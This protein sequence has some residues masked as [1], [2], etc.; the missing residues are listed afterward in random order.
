MT[1]ERTIGE[2]K[3][4]LIS[5]AAGLFVYGSLT[6]LNNVLTGKYQ[7]GFV[8]KLIYE[9]RGRQNFGMLETLTI[10]VMPYIA[11]VIPAAITYKLVRE[12]LD[13]V[14]PDIEQRM[15][16]EEIEDKSRNPK[17]MSKEIKNQEKEIPVYDDSAK[18]IGDPVDYVYSK[19]S[20]NKQGRKNG[21]FR[22]AWNGISGKKKCQEKI[23]KEKAKKEKK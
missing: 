1:E 23:L 2:G 21:L 14:Y 13:Y 8:Q 10:D 6:V 12:L 17:K 7:P 4:S 11:F 5:L 22:R 15:I 3:K 18:E 16:T 9:D 19:Y 20:R